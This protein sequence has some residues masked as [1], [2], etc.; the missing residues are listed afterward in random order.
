[1]ITLFF[2]A[3]ISSAHAHL[4]N[5]IF[6]LK[7]IQHLNYPRMAELVSTQ[8]PFVREMLSLGWP[9]KCLTIRDGVGVPMIVQPE[10]GSYF[11]DVHWGD[12]IYSCD[13]TGEPAEVL[14]PVSGQA[15]L[16]EDYE[17][18]PKNIVYGDYTKEL[19]I[20]DDQSGALIRLAHVVARPDFAY[21]SRRH[22]ERGEV[23]ARL[24]A[25]PEPYR[26]VHLEAFD[27]S[28]GRA[29]EPLEFLPH[30]PINKP[31]LLS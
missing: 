18:P 9:L 23:V 5:E 22:V 15:F 27:L 24:A 13:Q 1:M 26:H 12:D 19:W 6:Q 7:K 17:H 29:L 11:I 10:P 30:T 8:K 16:P 2:I 25:V 14:T 28:T 31:L 4:P 21:S 3:A 20:L